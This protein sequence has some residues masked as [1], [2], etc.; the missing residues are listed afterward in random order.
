MVQTNPLTEAKL[1]QITKG[2]YRMTPNEERAYK[3]IYGVE[4][5]RKAV[6]G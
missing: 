5:E 2:K 1:R 3:R 4:N 6:K